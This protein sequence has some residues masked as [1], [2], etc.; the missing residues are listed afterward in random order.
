MRPLHQ[1]SLVPLPR[2]GRRTRKAAA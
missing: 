1:R 2:W